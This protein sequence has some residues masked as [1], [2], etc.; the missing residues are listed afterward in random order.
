MLG[1]RCVINRPSI[2]SS[3]SFGDRIERARSGDQSCFNDLLAKWR[4]Y[5]RM[6]ARDL[7]GQ[8]VA[9]R[10]DSSDI[11]QET[12]VQAHRNLSSFRGNTRFE[13]AGWLKRILF[14][15]VRRTRRYH[16]ADKRSVAIET[17]MDDSGI[18]QSSFDDRAS[19]LVEFE[20]GVQVVLALGQLTTLMRE[21]VV[22][23]VFHKQSFREIAGELN[24]SE[25]ATRVLW[26]RAIKRL[27]QVMN[28][29]TS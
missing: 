24:R 22:R 11:V 27:R 8:G 9:N 4:P 18:P 7:L 21:V 12:M 3:L 29:V 5:L 13:W 15:E 10:A 20:R 2:D 23:R 26:S 25:G 16:L 14:N 1:R 19:K 17:Q 28:E 6:R